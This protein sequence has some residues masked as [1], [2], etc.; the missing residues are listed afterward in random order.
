MLLVI[1]DEVGPRP[2]RH[3]LDET[4]ND[5]LLILCIFTAHP[6]LQEINHYCLVGPTQ[7]PSP[8][9]MNLIA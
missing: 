4:E 3:L 2:A 8:N 9:R 7:L 6:K 5:V 1:G